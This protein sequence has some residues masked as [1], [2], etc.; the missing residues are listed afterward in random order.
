MAFIKIVNFLNYF[1]KNLAK[2]IPSIRFDDEQEKGNRMKVGIVFE[3]GASRTMYSCGVMDALLEENIMVD[4]MIGVSAGIAYGV[5]Y[6]SRQKYRNL[7][8]MTQ[9][10]NDERY[11]GAKHLFNKQVKSLYNIPFVFGEIPDKLVPF[12]YKAFEAY[13]GETK[14]VVTNIHTGKAE[15]LDVPKNKKEFQN[16]LVASCSLP[17]VF[18]PAKIKKHYYLDG[19]ICDSIPFK[20]ALEDGCDKII[21]VLTREREYRKKKERGMHTIERMYRKYPKFVDAFEHRPENYNAQLDEL[22]EVEDRKEAYVIAPV[23]TFGIKRTESD[24]EKLFPLY[25]EGYQQMKYNMIHLK[26]FLEEE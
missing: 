3:G 17:L 8:I 14:A 10:F 22:R 23:S 15:Y 9:Y 19:G 20:K 6:V 26:K 12:D 11:M 5:S 1:Y 18:Q 4:Y 25:E 16:V 2:R 7:E 21:V 24:P 13:Q